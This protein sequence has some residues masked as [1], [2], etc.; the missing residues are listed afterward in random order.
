[1]PIEKDEAREDRI[2]NEAIV[3]AYGGEEQAIGWYYY[4]DDKITFPFKAKCISERKSSPLK[5]D[6]KVEVIELSP[7]D[8]CQHDMLVQIRLLDRVF[9]V[10][11]AQLDPL[12]VDESTQEAIADWHY[13]VARGYVF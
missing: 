3:D 10:P 7:A 5:A 1:M 12:D 2:H 13:W 8:D 4:L 9:G 11:L 6:E